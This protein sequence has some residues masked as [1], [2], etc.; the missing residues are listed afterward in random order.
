MN[1]PFDSAPPSAGPSVSGPA[2]NHIHNRNRLPSIGLRL[3]LRLR[4]RTSASLLCISL[5]LASISLV[6]SQGTQADYERAKSLRR[7]TENK[8][9]RD[10]VQPT[11]LSGSTQ[12]WYQVRS[13]AETHEYILVNAV[14]GERMTAF[15][16]VKLA[17]ALTKA[18]I[19]DVRPQRL[20]LE[21][22]E[23]RLSENTLE[24]RKAGKRWRCDLLNYELR[25]IAPATDEPLH[26]LSIED[27][28]KASSRTGPETSLTFVNRT[29]DEVELFWLNT[30]GARQSYGKLE[31]GAEREQHTFAGHVWQATDAGGKT[32][33]VFQAEERPGQAAI[34]IRPTGE[35]PR[36][37][38]ESRRRG[39]AARELAPDGKWRAYVKDHNLMVRSLEDGEEV[40]L[41][42]DGTEEDSYGERV[43][44]S[45]DSKRLV[46]IRTRA[47]EEHKVYLVESS[48]K[49]QVQPKLHTVDYRKPGDR[50]P[51]AKPQLFDVIAQRQ[52]PVNDELF[53]NPWSVSEVRWDSDSS[54]FT[55][56]YNQRGHEVLRI[57]GV[58]A[59]TGA[60]K[61]IVDE[62]SKTFIDYSGKSFTEYLDDTREIIWM[63]ERDGWNHL[64][65]YDA[66]SGQVKN[67]MTKGE[68]VVRGVERVDKEKRQI[69]FRAGG[70][71]PGQDPYYIHFARVNFDGNGLVVLTEG[72]GTHAIEFSPD[73]RFF[74]DT[75][76]RV[77]QPPVNELRRSDDGKRVCEL[78]RA[79]WSGLLKTGWQTPERFVARARDGETDI[80]GIINRPT[81]FDPAKKYP[82]IENIYAG[83]QS[84]F[85]PKAFSSLNRMQEL[86]ELGF[87]VVQMDGMGT[88]HRSKKFH[89]VCWKNIG[90]AGFPD[91]ILWLKA[92]AAKYPYLDLS[93]VGIYGG[94]AGGQN[95]LRALLAHG[96]FY[97]AA[98]ADCG[99]HDNR[100]DKI[101]WNEQ[102]MGWPI[103]SHYDEQSN[104]TQAHKLQGKLLLTVAELDKNV[105][106]ASTMQVVNALIK[107]DKDFELI[108]FPGAGH[109][110]GGSPYGRRR[111]QDFFVRHLL[112]VEPRSGS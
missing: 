70:I 101:W 34:T 36:R 95:A 28:P 51:V 66:K 13:G 63:S 27:A 53:Q 59:R 26:S 44:W 24:F 98:V 49:D 107:A 62:Q 1:S 74:I 7:L 25:E 106:P 82:V 57:V 12:F 52:I 29:P 33:A 71:V 50:V 38:F 75:W 30:E 10:R 97:K 93:R 46:A 108:V 72:D 55:F 111:M 109:G 90:D 16:H 4:G 88:S 47:G 92:A 5:S 23:F 17:G 99:C 56:L 61:P 6:H 45:P 73:R 110:A 91:R 87:I 68:W 8:V 67:Q 31:A 58:D 94:S 83:P 32:I 41:S 18:G 48:P 64:Y 81:N 9:F 21:R 105:D 80:Y 14:K 22:P 102:W 65:L 96:D 84:S 43:Y 35:S 78:E 11:W 15:D 60:V 37:Q 40:A 100:M 89:D 104:V 39:S 77:D 103:G 19:K 79:D 86:A 3:G 20:A 54:R 69:W 112:G 85:T 42:S 76:S 2:H